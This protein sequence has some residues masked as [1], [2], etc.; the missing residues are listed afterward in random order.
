MDH[1]PFLT[2]DGCNCSNFLTGFIWL[3]INFYLNYTIIFAHRILC[4][5]VASL[6]FIPVG[7]QHKQQQEKY[8]CILVLVF[9]FIQ[10]INFGGLSLGLILGHVLLLCFCFSLGLRRC[11]SGVI[12]VVLKKN[13]VPLPSSPDIQ[14]NKALNCT[15]ALL[16]IEQYKSDDV[17]QTYLLLII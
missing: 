16:I 7:H 4:C 15:L 6:F 3:T 14:I 17:S 11:C 13:L 5:W 10:C 9:F 12:C 8:M 2:K 1:K